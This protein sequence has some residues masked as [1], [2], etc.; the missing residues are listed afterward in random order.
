M[1]KREAGQIAYVQVA[2]HVISLKAAGAFGEDDLSD[3]D[4]AQVEAA[5]EAIIQD[6]I[7]KSGPQWQKVA[8]ANS[9]AL[10]RYR[11]E[12]SDAQETIH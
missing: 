1:K 4:N 2:W 9:A 8:D 3:E 6:L 7:R 5:V 12:V 11:Q 10:E